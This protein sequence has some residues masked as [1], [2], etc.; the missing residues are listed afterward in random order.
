MKDNKNKTIKPYLKY[1]GAL[2][3]INI[4]TTSSSNHLDIA[5]RHGKGG[6][7]RS[8]VNSSSY[9]E[10]N[11]YVYLHSQRHAVYEYVRLCTC[12]IK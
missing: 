11:T 7:G 12:A 2:L 1:S 9:P 6:R 5:D 4:L 10:R 3:I 8:A